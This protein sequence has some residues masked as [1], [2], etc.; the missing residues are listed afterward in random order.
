MRRGRP[1]RWPRQAEQPQGPSLP[2]AQPG[3]TVAPKPPTVEQYLAAAWPIE[4]VSA[5]KA[6]RMAWISYERG[7][8][9]V[10]TAAAPDFRPVRLTPFLERQRHRS[11]RPSASPTTAR[12]WCS[13]AA[14]RRTATAGS[15][16]RPAIR[17][18]PS[19]PSGRRAPRA[20][21]PGGWPRAPT[22][23]CRPTAGSWLFVKDGQIYRVPVTRRRRRSRPIDKGEKPFI[24]AWGTNGNPRWSPDGTKIAFVSDRVDHSFIAVYDVRKRTVTY[25]APSVDRDTSPTWSADS[26]RD[27]VHPPARAC[28]SAA[29]AAGRRGHRATR[30][31]AAAAQGEAAARARGGAGRGAW[32]A[33]PGGQRW[34]RGGSAPVGPIDGLTAGGV[35]GR[36]HAVV[37]GG[38]CGDRRGA[39]V[40]AQPAG[41]A[42]VREHQRHPVGRRHTS[43]SRQS[44]KSGFA[45]T[46]CAVS[47]S[48]T[49][50]PTVLT[51]GDGM[52]ENIALS[53]DGRTLVLLHERRR[54][55]AAPHLE[56]ADRGRRGG[57]AHQG[58]G[59]R[60]L[61]GRARLG[62]HVA[63]LS[64]DVEP[65]A[66]GGHR[67][68]GRRRGED[69]LPDAAEGFPARRA[70]RA[71]RTS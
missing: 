44:R 1:C 65:A 67:R 71:R 33:A 68:R 58:R 69:H 16:I 51:P 38:R 20:A 31:A 34:R 11:H 15:P 9:N 46:R 17:T 28:R 2:A 36:L 60:N 40:L 70:R 59:H 42:H 50:T 61:P 64:A 7:E 18:A 48:Q 14:T 49:P 52:V 3:Q 32:P 24:K 57:A 5:K 27:R 10:Y 6:D 41:R 56:G 4:L 30:R 63:V 37:L 55:R 29:G 22:R 54:H 21:P 53:S 26:K 13:C 19:A 39:R 47:A 62:K 8:R 23:R 35:Q 43:S 25:L 66:V 12:W 45:T